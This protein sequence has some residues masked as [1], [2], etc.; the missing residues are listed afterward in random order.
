MS[1]RQNGRKPKTSS[2]LHIRPE[3]SQLSFIESN[4]RQKTSVTALRLSVD[5]LCLLLPLLVLLNNQRQS[6]NKELL[7]L[8]ELLFCLQVELGFLQ[9]LNYNDLLILKHGHVLGELEPL[10]EVNYLHFV[11][12]QLL[13]DLLG[14]SLKAFLLHPGQNLVGRLFD[15]LFQRGS[16]FG[17]KFGVQEWWQL[18]LNLRLYQLFEQ[19]LN[20]N[21]EKQLGIKN[22]GLK[23]ERGGDKL[24]ENWL[25]KQFYQKLLEGQLKGEK[26]NC[27]LKS[28][29]LPGIQVF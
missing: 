2:Q 11:M 23:R 3:M 1:G 22:L 15:K 7:Q 24:G 14:A 17:F 10:Q 9:L 28:L 20:G 13:C 19:K 4:K 6:L 16:H 8:L 25:Q 18:L 26:Y 27:L 5:F 21:E 29:I 12:H